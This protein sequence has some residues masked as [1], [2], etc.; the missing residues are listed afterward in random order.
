[1]ASNQKSATSKDI[2]QD[3]VYIGVNFLW[4]IDN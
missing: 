1:M 2:P 4:T 3:S